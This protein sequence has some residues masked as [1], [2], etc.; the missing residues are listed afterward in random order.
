MTGFRF[1][2][3]RT[4]DTDVHECLQHRILIGEVGTFEGL[5]TLPF[6]DR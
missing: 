3:D 6:E 5:A 1:A 4:M 2:E